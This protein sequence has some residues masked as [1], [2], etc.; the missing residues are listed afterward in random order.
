MNDI[1]YAATREEF[2]TRRE[3]F[4]RKWRIQHEAVAR[5][6]EETGDRLLTFTRLPPA[7][8]RS[9]RTTKPIDQPIDLGYLSRTRMLLKS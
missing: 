6:L 2:E 3:A 5:S 8:W 7:L 9:V 1:I 4:I